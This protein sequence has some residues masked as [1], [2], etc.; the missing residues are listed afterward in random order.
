MLIMKLPESDSESKYSNHAGKQGGFTL[1]EILVSLIILA[2]G[3]LGLAALQ[4]NSVQ[5]TQATYFRT[6]AD[7]LVNDLAE[8]MRSNRAGSA[9]QA[10]AFAGGSAP[11]DPGCGATAQCTSAALATSDLNEWVTWV[12]AA[13][14]GG[15]ATIVS[16]GANFWQIRVMWDERK[17]GATGQGCDPDDVDDMA[18]LTLNV[19]IRGVQNGGTYF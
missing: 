8:R 17:N 10:Y 12:Q 9:V 6:Q 2:V 14:P 19:E 18:C 11:T 4:T 3:F 1:I 5:G 15:D 7:L 13:L 16:L